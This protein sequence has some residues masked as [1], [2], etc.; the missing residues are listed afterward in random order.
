MGDSRFARCLQAGGVYVFGSPTVSLINC[1]V[2]SNQALGN[3]VSVRALMFKSSHRPPLSLTFC[4]FV[5]RAAVSISMVA[6]W[7]SR[8]APSVGIQL[9]VCAL[10]LNSSHRPDGK[11]ADVLARLTLA[12][13]RMLR[14]NTECTC[15]RDIESSHRPHGRLTICSL[16][17]GRRCLCRAWHG[18]LLIVHHQWE[19]S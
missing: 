5:C 2:H 1:Q 15:H 11:M 8:R 9:P 18:D 14:S 7:P 13:M 10:T 17:T 16:F 6:R 3:S 4:S 12:Q 19:Y